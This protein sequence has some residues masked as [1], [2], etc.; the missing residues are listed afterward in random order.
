MPAAEITAAAALNADPKIQCGKSEL[1]IPMPCH[2][3]V[4]L[5]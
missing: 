3:L 5:R 2:D 1:Q 4:G